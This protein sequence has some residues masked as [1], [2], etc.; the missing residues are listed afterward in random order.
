M[1]GGL[2]ITST[3]PESL[4][5]REYEPM[6][7]QCSARS[8]RDTTS[9]GR[10]AVRKEGSSRVIAIAASDSRSSTGGELGGRTRAPSMRARAHR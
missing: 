6:M 8:G 10:P 9:A 7:R 5:P 1:A 2:T 3:S 4:A